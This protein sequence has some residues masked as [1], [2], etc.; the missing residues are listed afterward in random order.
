MSE[1]T[2]ELYTLLCGQTD[3]ESIQNCINRGAQLVNVNCCE[4]IPIVFAMNNGQ[5]KE[6]IELLVKNGG[7][8]IESRPIDQ[9]MFVY[10]Q[11]DGTN[12]ELY[13]LYYNNIMNTLILLY[14]D[15][16]CSNKII[17]QIIKIH[18]YTNKDIIINNDYT[19]YMLDYAEILN[20]RIREYCDILHIDY[21]SLSE[22][23]LEL[24]DDI[25]DCNRISKSIFLQ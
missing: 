13:Y 16:I 17:N 23:N 9:K 24:V 8:D 25:I 6:V 18:P 3:V 15:S 22:I 10:K 19:Q 5:P 11:L 21:M 14:H 4:G 7:L 2:K 12:D 20:K 1:A